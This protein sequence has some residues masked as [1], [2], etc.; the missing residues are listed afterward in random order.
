MIV[1]EDDKKLETNKV[2]E[3]FNDSKMSFF[4]E[5]LMMEKI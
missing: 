3:I 2:R 4:E 1:L 5:D